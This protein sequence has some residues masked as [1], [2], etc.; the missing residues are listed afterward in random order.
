MLRQDAGSYQ[1]DRRRDNPN[2]RLAGTAFFVMM[3]VLVTMPM[4][5]ASV[6]MLFA[7]AF[8]FV[9]VA[10]A[11]MMVFFHNRSIYRLQ[12]YGESTAPPIPIYG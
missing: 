4:A 11:A 2:N 6:L 1:Q 7:M 3:V 10:M 8:V 9:L 12:R 5:L